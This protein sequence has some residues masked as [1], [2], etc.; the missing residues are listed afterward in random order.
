MDLLY[1]ILIIIVFV[2]IAIA[3]G[4]VNF[5][6]CGIYDNKDKKVKEQKE[7]DLTAQAIDAKSLHR[8]IQKNHTLCG[9]SLVKLAERRY[10]YVNDDGKY[11]NN[12]IFSFANDFDHNVAIVCKSDCEAGLIKADGKYIIPCKLRQKNLETH[13]KKVFDGIY[14]Y[15]KRFY[16]KPSYIDH[17]EK[18]L[19]KADG[20]FIYN[21]YA[22][23]IEISDDD[24][25]LHDEKGRVVE[26]D[27]DGYLWF[28][29]CKD[30]GDLGDGLFKVL[31]VN[32]WGIYDDNKEEI[33]IPCTFSQILYYKPLDIII[34]QPGTSPYVKN[35]KNGSNIFFKGDVVSIIEHKYYKVSKYNQ[36]KKMIS[37]IVDLN[38]KHI[39]QTKYDYVW[40]SE[41]GFMVSEKFD[42]NS[43]C[44]FVDND[45]NV[46]LEYNYCRVVLD[47]QNVFS[48][49]SMPDR[50]NPS[51]PYIETFASKPKLI[52]VSKNN[53]YGLVTLDN[54][55]TIPIV[56]D[57]IKLCEDSNLKTGFFIVKKDGL[58]GLYDI[59]CKELFPP[60]YKKIKP[61]FE[62][63]EEYE[64]L[65]GEYEKIRMIID[66]N[67]DIG[68]VNAKGVNTKDNVNDKNNDGL[69]FDFDEV[70]YDLSDD[71]VIQE[72][73][74]FDRFRKGKRV[75]FEVE[76]ID[77]QKKKLLPNGEPFIPQPYH[78]PKIQE[79]PSIS[80][81]VFPW[82]SEE[83]IIERQREFLES[84]SVSSITEPNSVSLL[85]EGI[86]GQTNQGKTSL[87]TPIC[88]PWDDDTTQDED[89]T[90]SKSKTPSIYLF[91]DTETNGLPIDY[92]AP[93]S[94]VNNWPRLIR[95]SWIITDENYNVIS[96][97]DHI[98][99]PDGFTIPNDVAIMHGITNLKA[100][101]LGEPVDTIL[102]SFISDFNKS[103]CIVG[104]NV[105]FDKKIIGAEL[106]RLGRKD[107]MNSK[108]S[109][110][111]MEASTDYCK[112]PG[113]HGYKWPKLQELH[114]KLFGYGFEDAHNSLCDVTATL[115]C[116]QELRRINVISS[117][118]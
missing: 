59:R 87:I 11:L 88:L 91:F 25:K 113:S 102:D 89:V 27:F 35:M 67:G 54:E 78:K 82:D 6:I 33:I 46:N 110:C 90:T 19:V 30:K 69:V 63:E 99:Y 45:G 117:T 40:P 103:T 24:I 55:I 100:K 66:E 60:F 31:D 29:P 53:K 22:D 86:N 70:S 104:H 39:V 58:Y 51:A 79:K 7:H 42:N 75:Y 61:H 94:N 116:F 5:I 34:L 57:E 28:M 83:D 38:G 9:W 1:F 105:D 14:E 107:V 20:S 37:G 72:M 4:G 64:E 10:A 115:K 48:T 112:I 71:D 111:T 12:E 93:S 101:Q 47:T 32:G 8:Y 18:S 108:P 77:G 16:S 118:L 85:D 50:K 41:K 92:K 95:L 52:M 74:H 13:I 17:V 49:I 96:S 23:I 43:P 97:N 81:P 109:I 36:D 106:V 98:I 65:D 15:E 3:M 56:Y 2:I 80:V 114:E 44:G 84:Q 26:I 73:L 21:G 62:H 76:Y 68:F